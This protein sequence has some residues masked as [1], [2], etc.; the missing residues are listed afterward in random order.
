MKDREFEDVLKKIGELAG[1]GG[2]WYEIG[3]PEE[4]T[5]C[6]DGNVRYGVYAKTD[7]A[8]E[9]VQ[10]V[11]DKLFASTKSFHQMWK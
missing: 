10:A 6:E 7:E 5:G 11:L 8:A 2:D 3:E 9:K 4:G 1:V